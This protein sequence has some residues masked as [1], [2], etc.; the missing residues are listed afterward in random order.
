L[1]GRGHRGAGPPR[2]PGGRQ[3]RPP[4]RVAPALAPAPGV[5][6]R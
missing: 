2:P 4:H 6:P 3:G 5:S 1:G